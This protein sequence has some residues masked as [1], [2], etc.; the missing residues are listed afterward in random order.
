MPTQPTRSDI[1]VNRPLTNMSIS[2]MQDKNDFIADKVFPAIPVKKQSDR[3]FVYTKEAWFRTEAAKRAPASE[4]VGTGFSLD[5]TPTYFCD[6][7]ALHMDI[8]DDERDNQD[9]PLDIEFDATELVTQQLMIR[10]EKLFM[11]NY[12]TTGVWTGWQVSG[13][14]V[15]YA[16]NT[17]GAGYWDSSTSNPMLD[18][19][20]IRSQVK[21]RTGRKPNKMVVTDNVFA[22]LKN[23]PSVLDRIKYTQRGIITEEL[24]AA[25]F[26]VQ[27]FLV[28]GAVFNSA[29]EG[30]AGNF[31]F[32]SNNLFLLAYAP[33][34]PG[35]RKPSAGYIFQWTGKYGA[36]AMGTR[37]KK[38]RMEA[39]ASDRIEVEMGF[40]MAQ[41]GK[42]LGV[43]GVSVLQNP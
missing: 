20:K 13:S 43:L 34:A 19:D 31:G 11:A 22:A 17:H 9:D 38:F 27:Q 2:Y 10:R 33:D 15:D 12:M 36:E 5:N 30:Q 14:P 3:Y 23:N 18:V 8:D 35:L 1:H 26:G 25:L 16:P 32:M 39:L 29:K 40:Q 28:A 21:S 7:W 24:L 6:K 41:T 4:S 37:V 42:D